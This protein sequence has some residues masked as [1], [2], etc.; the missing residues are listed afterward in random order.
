[1][2]E[3]II[4][5]HDI[6]GCHKRGGEGLEEQG[7]QAEGT[8][9]VGADARAE[10]KKAKEERADG[11]E[12]ADEDEREHKSGEVVVLVRAGLYDQSSFNQYLR[13]YGLP[14]KLRG[15]ILL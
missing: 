1:M 7:N 14:D 2:R 8:G 5:A 10:G 11:E 12:E 15:Y 6:R 4:P 3:E 9:K 13:V